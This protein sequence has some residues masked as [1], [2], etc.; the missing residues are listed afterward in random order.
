MPC[1][2]TCWSA[3]V[4][5]LISWSALDLKYSLQFW[6]NYSFRNL[7]RWAF[8]EL[9]W[10]GQQDVC[11]CWGKV[12]AVVHRFYHDQ[13]E[14]RNYLNKRS[15]LIAFS[16]GVGRTKRYARNKRHNFVADFPEI[17]QTVTHWIYI[18]ADCCSQRNTLPAMFSV[19]QHIYCTNTVQT[20]QS[21]TELYLQ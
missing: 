14:S 18:A 4:E 19:L 12:T 11:R 6:C 7:F 15:G 9:C 8:N 17:T 16:N 21:A 3:R 20:V 2:P 5:K 13:M 10:S 1:D